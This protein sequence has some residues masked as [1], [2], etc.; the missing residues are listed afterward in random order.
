VGDNSAKEFASRFYQDLLAG[1]SIGDALQN[2]RKA[3]RAI[4]SRDWADYVFY[5]SQ[6]FVLK[7]KPAGELGV[8]R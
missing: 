4:P 3:V 5:G 1:S 7:E 6:D 2:G 8:P